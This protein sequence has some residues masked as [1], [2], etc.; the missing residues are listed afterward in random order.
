MFGKLFKNIS[1]KTQGLVAL[2]IG[3]LLLLG[4]FGHLGILQA[5]FNTIKIIAGVVLLFW[6]LEKSELLGSLKKLTK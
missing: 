4:A 1:N 3:T 5:F 6:G 2:A